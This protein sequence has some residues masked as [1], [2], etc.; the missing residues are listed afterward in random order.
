MSQDDASLVARVL[1]G[2]KSAF[3]Q[4]LLTPEEVSTGLEA[5]RLKA[6]EAQR[7]PHEET[8]MEY[9]SFRSLPRGD[10]GGLLK[11]AEK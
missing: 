8:E 11:P 1:A 9:R 2:E 4:L 10:F 6:V 5:I 3:A 7:I